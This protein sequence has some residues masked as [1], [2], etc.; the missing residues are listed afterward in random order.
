[1][2]N[3]K[4]NLNFNILKLIP[5]QQVLRSSEHITKN[6]G[7]DFLVP[8]LGEGVLMSTGKKWRDGILRDFGGSF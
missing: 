6:F 8:W 5:T 4:K 1:M 3:K 7:Y 2:K